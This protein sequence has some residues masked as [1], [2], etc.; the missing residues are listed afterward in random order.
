LEWRESALEWRE[1]ALEWRESALEW[2]ESALEWRESAL[3]LPHPERMHLVSE[4]PTAINR[5]H[6]EEEDDEDPPKAER[7]THIG[8]GFIRRAA[9]DA[10]Q[11]KEETV[12]G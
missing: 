12:H 4:T 10:R 9:V 5:P 8:E 6:D 3:K 1:S 7:V 2:R 11:N